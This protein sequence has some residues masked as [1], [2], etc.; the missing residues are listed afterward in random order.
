MAWP[1]RRRAP[2]GSPA[3]EE[4][5][6]V[7]VMPLLR[8]P[9]TIDAVFVVDACR[10]LF[11]G[12]VVGHADGDDPI[13]IE[14]DGCTVHVAG[15]PVPI[16]G[17]EVTHAGEGSVLWPSANDELAGYGAHAVVFVGGGADHRASC[18]VAQRAV[19]AVL[20][21]TD[22]IG[23]Y[24]GDAGLVIRSDLWIDRARDDPGEL[25]APFWF[26]TRVGP[27][28]SGTVDAY[29]VGLAPFGVP[30]LEVVG[31]TLPPGEVWELVGDIGLYL[32]DNGDVIADG[33]TV[34]TTA[35]QK[36]VARAVPSSFGLEGTVLRLSC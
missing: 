25:F 20:D 21:A 28:T 9:R 13:S 2:T 35:E 6:P 4:Q 31:S 14:L 1:K 8:E 22:A 11:P 15:M 29:T 16:P 23:V 7:L 10:R 5:V 12:S 18:L 19:A 26:D 27:N 32:I 24:V 34:G 36:I 30:E 3:R 17:D 33:H